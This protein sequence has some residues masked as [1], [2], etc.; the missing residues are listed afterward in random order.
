M[1]EIFN[2]IGIDSLGLD[3]LDRKYLESIQVKFTG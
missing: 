2:D 1:E 3:Y